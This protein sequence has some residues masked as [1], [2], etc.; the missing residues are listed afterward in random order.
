MKYSESNKPVVCMQTNNL[1][2]KNT[3]AMTP[4]GVLWHSTGAN[5][6]YI[7]RYVQPLE[8]DDNY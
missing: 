3:T 1:C 5:N 8:T 4:Q 6:P 7:H 2:Y